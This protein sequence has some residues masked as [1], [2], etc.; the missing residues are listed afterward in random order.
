M[1]VFIDYALKFAPSQVVSKTNYG[2]GPPPFQLDRI[3][4]ILFFAFVC[5]F[6][7]KSD[8]K[9]RP[10][11]SQT[12]TE[13]PNPAFRSSCLDY[14]DCL[15]AYFRKEKKNKKKTWLDLQTPV[16]QMVFTGS[17]SSSEF[18]LRSLWPHLR[19]CM[20]RQR[21][22]LEACCSPVT[23]VRLSWST[24]GCSLILD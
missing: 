10:M 18:N 15:F 2:L 22:T 20:V 3:L 21:P 1:Y 6:Q 9:L 14:S 19:L 12:K 5:F 7:L 13:T 16:L 24:A 4:G 8:A 23:L 17:L 11:M